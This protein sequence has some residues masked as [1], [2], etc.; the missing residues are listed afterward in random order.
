MT[1]D[2]LVYICD[3][4]CCDEGCHVE[5]PEPFEAFRMESIPEEYGNEQGVYLVPLSEGSVTTGYR[6]PCKTWFDHKPER[7]TA[8]QAYVENAIRPPWEEVPQS[9]DADA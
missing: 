5:D 2:T 8:L 9:S 4:E 3:P 1:P 7:M 6:M